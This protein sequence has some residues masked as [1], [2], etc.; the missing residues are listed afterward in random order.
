MR[1][2]VAVVVSIRAVQYPLESLNNMRLHPQTPQHCKRL[3]VAVIEP[4]GRG[5]ALHARASGGDFT[6]CWVFKPHE[7][8]ILMPLHCIACACVCVSVMHPLGLQTA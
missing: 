5:T 4:L 8:A 2:C 7:I 3:Y 6:L 1:V